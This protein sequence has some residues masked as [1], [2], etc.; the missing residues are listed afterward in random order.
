MIEPQRRLRMIQPERRRLHIDD[1][2]FACGKRMGISNLSLSL[3]HEYH[4]TDSLQLTNKK[5][6]SKQHFKEIIEEGYSLV[7]EMLFVSVYPCCRFGA[8]ESFM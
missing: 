3:S 4:Q 1:D 6:G 8:K 5:E 2:G 7:E